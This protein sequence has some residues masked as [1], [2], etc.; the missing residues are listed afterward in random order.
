MRNHGGGSVAVFGGEREAFTEFVIQVREIR[1]PFLTEFVTLSR[2]VR[3]SFPDRGIHSSRH[4][5]PVSRGL[6]AS[7]L[8]REMDFHSILVFE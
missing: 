4:V 7:A 5:S 2:L 8:V 3:V 6:A 1:V